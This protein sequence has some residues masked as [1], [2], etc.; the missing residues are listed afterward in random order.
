MTE[1]RRKLNRTGRLVLLLTQLAL[2]LCLMSCHSYDPEPPSTPV[3][4]QP[5]KTALPMP[6]VN[7]RSLGEM[8]WELTD[9]RH[10]ILNDYKGSVLVLDFYATWC[11]PCRVSVP[12]LVALQKKYASKALKVVGLNVGGPGDTQKVPAFAQEFSIQYPLAMPDDGLVGFLMSD[13]TDIPQTFV[14]DRAGVLQKRVIG[15]DPSAGDLIE[16]VIQHALNN[17]GT[18]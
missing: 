14:F 11:E 1:L 17:T 15:F 10:S 12:E 4:S 3:G 18:D 5:P 16:K 2:L 6:P 9:G 7:R 13:R 8:G